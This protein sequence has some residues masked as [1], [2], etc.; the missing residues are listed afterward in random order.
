MDAQ[1][2]MFLQIHR[3]SEQQVMTT[4]CVIKRNDPSQ[5]TLNET[6]GIYDSLGETVYEGVCLVRPAQKEF[7]RAMFG[8]EQASV[9]AYD[10]RLPYDTDVEVL[11]VITVT[12][13]SDSGLVGRHLVIRDVLHDEW[14]TVRKVIAEEVR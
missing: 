5:A 11:D 8:E 2:Q 13:S 14:M 3:H 9:H 10:V 6:T 4:R 12:A 7:R 1:T